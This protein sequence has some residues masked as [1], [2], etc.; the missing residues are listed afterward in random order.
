MKPPRIKRSSFLGRKQKKK[1]AYSIEIRRKALKELSKLPKKE[2]LRVKEAI[3]SL[4]QEPRPQ[5][6]K[7]LADKSNYWRIRVGKYRVVYH[8][9]DDKLIVIIIK[10]S[11]RKEVYR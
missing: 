3:D 2:Q 9:E 8:I 4:S 7:K 6:V 10:I 11:H 1:L 5:G